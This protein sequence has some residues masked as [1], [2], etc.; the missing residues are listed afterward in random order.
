MHCYRKPPRLVIGRILRDQAW[1]V[2]GASHSA[3]PGQ[4][5][6]ATGT[7]ASR[8]CVA[9]WRLSTIPKPLLSPQGPP[10]PH[11]IAFPDPPSPT[12]RLFWPSLT[13]A[14]PARGPIPCCTDGKLPLCVRE[15]GRCVCYSVQQICLNSVVLSCHDA[16]LVIADVDFS[17]SIF[18]W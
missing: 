9:P 16:L 7:P 6:D 18:L 3:T 15:P 5:I 8:P 1:I 11:T 17:L 2:G 4:V 13:A 12:P 10:S 14:V